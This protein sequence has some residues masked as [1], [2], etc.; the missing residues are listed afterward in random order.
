MSMGDAAKSIC[1]Q[2]AD[3][4]ISVLIRAVYFRINAPGL[5]QR[6]EV[7]LTACVAVPEVLNP[8]HRYSSGTRL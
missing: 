4:S 8:P 3:V 2:T 5:Y 6:R 7:M 1:G